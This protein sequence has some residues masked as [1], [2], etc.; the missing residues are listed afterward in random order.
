MMTQPF[1]RVL[2]VL[3]VSGF[4]P[5]QVR[6]HGPVSGRSLQNPVLFADVADGKLIH[7][8]HTSQARGDRV[9]IGA[10]IGWRVACAAG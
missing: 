7:L 10:M 5:P 4:S 6:V 3:R 9:M 8:M 2:R 1:F